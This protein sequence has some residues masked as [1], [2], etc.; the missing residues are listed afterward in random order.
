MNGFVAIYRREMLS[1]WVSPLAWV[2]LFVFLII[3]G[4]S[5]YLM[6][7]HFANF[8]GAT[9]D[10]GPVAAYFGQSIFIPISLIILCPALTMRLFA[11]ERRAGT[12]ETLMT[13]PVTP[14]GVVLG[15]YLA[16]LTTYVLIWAPTLLY[17]VILRKTGTVDWPL[18]GSSYLGVF[19]IGAGYL[20]IGMLMSALTKSQLIALILS[21]LF[22]F[23]L[24]ILGIGEYVFQP[25]PLRD[26][27][28]HVSVFSQ[29]VDF[30]K[31]IVDL[32]RIVFDLTLA[33]LPLF[34]TARVVDS[35]RWD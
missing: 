6:V 3:Q 32:R 25:G 19:G 9:I 21:L 2:L 33:G 30:S 26:A 28:A 29:L 18:V 27:C 24:F 20:A 7:Q 10:Y 16:T 14:W 31:G 4:V 35:W 12:I 15:K 1:L 23:G 5:F 22:I 17:V 13:A 8:S 11:E 34:L